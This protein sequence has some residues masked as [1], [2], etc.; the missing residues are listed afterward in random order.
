LFHFTH[1]H[2]W[3]R[4]GIHWQWGGGKS[5]WTSSLARADGSVEQLKDS[6]RPR[7]WVNPAT[8]LPELLFIAS[9]G[10]SQPTKPGER[11]FTVVQRIR[12]VSPRQES[13]AKQR[14]VCSGKCAVLAPCASADKWTDDV[15][16]GKYTLVGAGNKQCL[17]VDAKVLPEGHHLELYACND[18]FRGGANQHFAFKGGEL[19]SKLWGAGEACVAACGSPA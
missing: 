2:G 12:A 15:V 8:K 14:G 5:A 7:V 1:G 9:G 19:S 16:P 11:G 17:D 4:D 18:A 6:E 13:Q 3:S 10:A